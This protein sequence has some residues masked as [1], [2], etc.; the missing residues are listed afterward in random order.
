MQKIT[1]IPYNIDMRLNDKYTIFG[2]SGFLGKNIIN[3]LKKKKIKYFLPQK[4]KDKI[5]SQFR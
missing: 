3:I 5:L 1:L 2:H 4:K